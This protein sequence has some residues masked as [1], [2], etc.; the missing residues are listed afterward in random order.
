M[1]E[2]K[3][4]DEEVIRALELHSQPYVPCVRT[5]PYG[6]GMERC[7]SHMAKDALDLITRQR[8]DIET[9]TAL[10]NLKNYKVKGAKT[11]TLGKYVSS[12]LGIQLTIDD[13]EDNT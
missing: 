8:E 7:G 3:F 10:I 11:K 9:L 4:T 1:T 6:R 2:H 5:C 13:M 12:D